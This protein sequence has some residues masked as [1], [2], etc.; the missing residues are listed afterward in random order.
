MESN[1]EVTRVPELPHV[2]LTRVDPEIVSYFESKGK[3]VLL[4]HPGPESMAIASAYGFSPVYFD[5]LPEVDGLK[6]KSKI[7]SSF[8]DPTR[9]GGLIMR[10]TTVLVERPIEQQEFWRGV[11]AQRQRAIEDASDDAAEMIFEKY[12]REAEAHGRSGRFVEVKKLS[13][14][15]VR[16]QGIG[17]HDLLEEVLRNE[18]E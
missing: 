10:G 3:Q 4:M 15:R 16:E 9:N 13:K 17:G 18:K 1:V 5:D 12:Q 11:N 2:E 6:I 14:A 7:R 8:E